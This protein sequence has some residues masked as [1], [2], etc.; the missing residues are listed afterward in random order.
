MVVFVLSCVPVPC[1]A[2]P[3]LLELHIPPSS[4]ESYY[5]NVQVRYLLDMLF[6]PTEY[7]PAE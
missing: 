7:L 4:L 3:S 5:V 1:Y 6:V 2:T